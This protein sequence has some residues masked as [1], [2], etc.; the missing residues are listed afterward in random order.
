M[1]VIEKDK[2]NQAGYFLTEPTS[3][4]DGST[5]PSHS[6]YKKIKSEKGSEKN[7]L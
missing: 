1:R 3:S 6:K 7:V 2:K 4:K 5:T